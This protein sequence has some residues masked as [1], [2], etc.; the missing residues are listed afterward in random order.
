MNVALPETILWKAL[1][2]RTLSPAQ[3]RALRLAALAALV[4][5]AA[6]LR[7]GNL[8]SLGYVNHYYSAAVTAMLQ[9]WHN[10]FFVAAEPG[11]AVSVDKPPLG[12]W[13]QVLSA[14]VLGVNTLGVLLPQLV[15][16]VL[17]VLVVDHLVRRAF[18]SAAGLL[19]ALALAVTPVAV[20]A[21]RNNTIDSTLI[22]TLLLAAWAFVLATESGRLR[23]L[24]LGAVLVG[25]GFN[26][27]M[28]E[29]YLPLPA[30]LA[31]YF[32]GAS[33]RLPRKVARLAL[34]GVVLLAVSLAWVLAVD[35]IPPG[36]RPYVGSSG[37]N[38]ELD[39]A[40]GYNGLNRLLGPHRGAGAA[41]VRPPV[42]R[43]S[44]G[45]R[46]GV[47]GAGG[48][49]EIGPLRLFVPP[50]SKEAG[51]LLPFGLCGAALL[52]LSA[53]PRWPLA[54]EHCFV[55]L[56]GGWLVTGGIFFSVA[57]FFHEYYLVTIAPPLAALVGAGAITLWRLRARGPWVGLMLLLAA[58]AVTL[59]LQIDT[60]LAFVNAVWWLPLV[61]ALLAAGAAL[62]AWCV[63]RPR[64]ALARAGFAC[65]LAALFVTPGVWSAL[66]MLHSSANQSLPAAYAGPHQSTG[67]ADR[68]GL[69][70]DHQLLEYLVAHT[71]GV[72]YLMAV[73]SS[74]QG[75][76]YV[77]ATRRPVLY[78]GGF[79]GQD[80]VAN[81][82][83]LARMTAD[84][85][86]RYIYWDA[87]GAGPGAPSRSD[88]S[89]WIRR[90]CT[91]VPGFETHTRN[92]GAPD[93]TG[94]A[95]GG[96]GGE[97]EISLYDC[98]R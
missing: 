36:E 33:D 68:G 25:L 64:D 13:L 59:A 31:L 70:V 5:L 69:R 83:D 47:G 58:A 77:L 30:F 12:L 38:S 93:G 45:A 94:G 8:A 98:G 9:S 85:E 42:F 71:A 41:P 35:V 17:S 44:A 14:Y 87:R 15:A 19:A 55:V 84:G 81:T 62:L 61:L 23:Y 92:A 72:K 67:P 65:V 60:A 66:T 73:P 90:H 57:G 89:G 21:D 51:W 56:W 6:V 76:D 34:A 48:V 80:Q 88:I 28:L 40:T 75:A 54:P 11:G 18:G 82:A 52:V 63:W 91:V 10:F 29:A 78:L 27:K 4:T 16:G 79:L 46:Q 49:G 96:P 53:R 3:A 22:L 24:L 2:G 37:D 32:L 50:L 43:P 26:I 97:L 20:A 7:F 86:L 1:A 74:M 95:S 39:L